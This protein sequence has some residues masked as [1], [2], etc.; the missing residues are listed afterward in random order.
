MCDVMLFIRDCL[1]G[2][3]PAIQCKKCRWA[4]DRTGDLTMTSQIIY[5]SQNVD[6]YDQLNNPPLVI[7]QANEL[8]IILF[9]YISHAVWLHITLSNI[10]SKLAIIRQY[11]HGKHEIVTRQ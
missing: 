9:S 1:H 6:Y 5:H 2:S 10:Y 7:Y 11:A 4:L 3:L 8:Y